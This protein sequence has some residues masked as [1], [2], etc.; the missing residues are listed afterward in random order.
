MRIA[1]Q[2]DFQCT[3]GN[4]DGMIRWYSQCLFRLMV[5]WIEAVGRKLFNVTLG[6]SSQLSLAKALGQVQEGLRNNSKN[7]LLI[8]Q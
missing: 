8:Q 4:D 2:W 5:V 1:A 3:Q 7:S 6:Q